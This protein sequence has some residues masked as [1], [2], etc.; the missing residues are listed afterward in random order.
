M[1]LNLWEHILLMRYHFEIKNIKSTDTSMF[2]S[3]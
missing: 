3:I 2:L 1:I